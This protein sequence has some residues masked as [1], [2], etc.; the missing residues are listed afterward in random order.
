MIWLTWRQFRMQALVAV[1]VLAAAAAYLLVTGMQLRHSYAADLASCH[2]P[3]AQY[4]CS[5]TLNG[6]QSQ[7]NGQLDLVGLLVM[8]APALIGIFWGAPLI[9]AELERGTHYLAW[10]QSVTRGR[11][12]A[13]KLVAVALASVL[14]AGLL[15]LLVTWWASPLD[16]LIG[17]RFG[18]EAFNG[19]NI[20]PLGYT[21]FAFALGV[22]LGL[23]IRRTLPA[24]AAALA[25]FVAVQILVTAD[26]RPHLL[27]ATTSAVA[28]NQASMNQALRLDLSDPVAIEVAPPPG[29]WILSETPL[30]HSSGE[31]VAPG[32]IRSC[33]NQF[34]NQDSSPGKGDSAGFGPLGAC[35][36][37]QSLHVGITY[38]PASRYWQLQWVETA[39]Y[40]VLAG[41][42]VAF[43]FRRIHKLLG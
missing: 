8:G 35:L 2:A 43:S 26:I 31:P 41:L 29:A 24:M 22:T 16:T 17:S 37:P 27:P 12:L 1:A 36:A 9:A 10:T 14:T 23:L 40:T 21:A 28:I 7:Y 32:G 30:L 42:L 33:L 19:R 11:W 39:L 13:A 20:V 5:G 25:I 4:T 18:T 15:S 34:M 3:N 38:Q 6:L